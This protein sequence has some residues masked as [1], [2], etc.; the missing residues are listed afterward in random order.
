MSK[1][2]WTSVLDSKVNE[3]DRKAGSA[4]QSDPVSAKR[5]YPAGRPLR[6]D[7]QELP[8]QHRPKSMST[9][10]YLRWDYSSHGGCSSQSDDCSKGKH[11]LMS[12]HGLHGSILMQLARRGG[13]R[14]GRKLKPEEID[15]YNQ[16]IRDS[17]MLKDTWGKEPPL[18]G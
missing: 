17:L 16:A 13:H 14:S 18:L 1:A 15:G 4:P 5:M 3:K 8:K 7:E 6:L 11:E 12:V 2:A 9:G 10:D